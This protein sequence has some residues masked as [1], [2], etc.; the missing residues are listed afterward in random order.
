MNKNVFNFLGGMAVLLL[1]ACSPKLLVDAPLNQPGVI[2]TQSDQMMEAMLIR[3]V[4]VFIERRCGD[5]H[6]EDCAKAGA[7]CV[8]IEKVDDRIDH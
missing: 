5:L 3:P 7:D 6:G 8:R 2:Y 4:G 1:T